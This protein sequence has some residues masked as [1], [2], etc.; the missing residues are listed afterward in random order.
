VTDDQEKMNDFFQQ[1]KL[2]EPGW[3]AM[4]T[5]WGFWSMTSWLRCVL[6]WFWW[7]HR[8]IQRADIVAQ[9]IFWF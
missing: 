8:P 7:R 9:N 1:N 2:V 4:H 5:D 6:L 3:L